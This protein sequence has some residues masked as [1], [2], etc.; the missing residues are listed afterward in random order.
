MTGIG[1]SDGWF[2]DSKS[3]LSSLFCTAPIS[4]SDVVAKKRKVMV[5]LHEN[6]SLTDPKTYASLHIN[7]ASA[8]RGGKCKCRHGMFIPQLQSLATQLAENIPHQ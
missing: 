1:A 5:L 3:L 7:A 2:S 8:F 4:G 6:N